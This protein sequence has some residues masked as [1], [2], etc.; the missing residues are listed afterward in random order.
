[1]GDCLLSSIISVTICF[2]LLLFS[3]ERYFG[4]GKLLISKTN[5]LGNAPLVALGDELK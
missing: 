3:F 1:V 2:I 4:N 5:I